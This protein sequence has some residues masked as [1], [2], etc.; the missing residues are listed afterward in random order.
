MH[1]LQCSGHICHVTDHYGMIS[2]MVALINAILNYFLLLC[3][4]LLN[5]FGC[6]CTHPGLCS[7]S[8]APC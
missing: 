8:A 2:G 3:R 5:V 6:S 7:A 1:V 4:V